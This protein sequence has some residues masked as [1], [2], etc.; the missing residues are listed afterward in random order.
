M[1]NISKSIL[2]L[3][4]IFSL[5]AEANT[6]QIELP[7]TLTDGKN[8]IWDI[9]RNGSIEDGSDDAFDNAAVV[10]NFPEFSTAQ[11]EN[12]C[13][14]II[15]PAQTSNLSITRKIFVSD[16]YGYAR[17]LESVHNPGETNQS[18]S[19]IITFVLGS[20]SSTHIVQ[21]S[22]NDLNLTR[23]DSWLIT[24]DDNSDSGDPTLLFIF[25]NDHGEKPTSIVQ[26]GDTLIC[27]FD[28]ELA[29]NQTRSIMYFVSQNQNQNQALENANR[30]SSLPSDTLQLLE[31]SERNTIQ[32]F[33]MPMHLIIPDSANESD[34]ILFNQATVSIPYPL[35]ETTIINIHSADT[36]EVTVPLTITMASGL[37]STS[38]D[39]NI[40]DDTILD[41]TQTVKISVSNDFLGETYA[42][43]EI[44]DNETATLTLELP[45]NANEGDGILSGRG[46]VFLS[47]AV[48]SPVKIYLSSKNP[49]KM[50]VPEYVLMPS[51]QDSVTFDL[52]IIDDNLIDESSVV[53][54]TAFVEGWNSGS[55][56]ITI[57]DN[58]DKNITITCPESFNENDGMVSG[59][60]MISLS[61]IIQNTLTVNLFSNN[62]S[63]LTVPSMVTIPSGEQSVSFPVFVINN[64]TIDTNK[65]VQISAS[66]TGWND[67]I[68]STTIIDDESRILL[69]TI[70]E[71]A[72]EG[73]GI[74]VNAGKIQI[75]GITTQDL[76]ANIQVTP[77]S[78]ISAPLSLTI[79][80]GNSDADF[81]IQIIDDDLLDGSQKI[82]IHVT[83]T[84]FES[85]S[86]TIFVHDN[87]TATLTLSMP[88]QVFE[89]QG[90]LS[91]Q[92]SVIVNKTV[93]K[94]IPIYL[95]SSDTT[96]IQVPESI[97]IPSGSLSSLFTLTVIDDLE[98]DGSQTATITASV[99][100][101]ISAAYNIE[102]QDNN[103]LELII[104]GEARETDEIKQGSVSISGFL[105]SDLVVHLSSSDSSEVEVPLTLTISAGTRSVSF[106]LSIV[107]DQMIDG[108]QVA[109][110][111]ASHENWIQD[112]KYIKILEKGEDSG[113]YGDDNATNNIPIG[114]DFDYWGNSYSSFGVST[115]G[116]ISLLNTAS[117]TYGNTNFPDPK[118][119]DGIIAPFFDD[120]RMDSTGQPTG[121]VFYLTIGKEP[122]RIL[123][124]QYHDVYFFGS[125][126]PMG[127]FETILYEGTNQIKFQYRFLRDE[128]S[129]GNSAT[130]GLDCP[131]T[132]TYLR[133]SYN[134]S[135]LTEQK[136]ILFDPDGQGGYNINENAYYSWIDISGLT[137]GAPNDGGYY[138]SDK[139]LFT[140][141]PTIN[142]NAYRLDISTS[143]SD[144]EIIESIELSDVTS[145]LYT[146]NLI[147]DETYY[148]RIAASMNNGG[149]YQNPSLFSDGIL[150]DKT[151]PD[152]NQPHASAGP[153]NKS[154]IFHFSGTDNNVITS[155][156]IQIS[157]KPDDFSDPLIDTSIVT[158]IFSYNGEPQQTLFARAFAI[159]AAGNKSQASTISNEFVVPWPPPVIT[160]ITPDHGKSTGHEIVTIR[161]LYFQADQADSIITFGGTP[162]LSYSRWTST[163]II[164]EAPP[165]T[166]GSHTVVCITSSGTGRLDNAFTMTDPV[167]HLNSSKYDYGR[168]FI[169]EEF[170]Y[171]LSI[172]NTGNDFLTVSQAALTG[173][174][175]PNFSLSSDLCSAHSLTPTQRCTL[176]I[177]FTPK[178]SG[179]I[180][181]Q[182]LIYSNDPQHSP[183]SFILE[184][185]GI[186]ADLALDECRHPSLGTAGEDIEV[187][188]S[189]TNNGPYE[190]D[191]INHL[192]VDK[193]FLSFDEQV[194]EDD[195]EIGSFEYNS[196]LLSSENYSLTKN[197]QLPTT[198][199]GDYWI[200]IATDALDQVEEKNDI[201]NF[202][203]CSSINIKGP[204]LIIEIIDTP[205]E[206][207]KGQS[208][209][210]KWKV[211]NIGFGDTAHSWKDCIYL[212]NDD[213][214][215]GDRLVACKDYPVHLKPGD[216]YEE[217]IEVLIPEVTDGQHY[218]VLA[219]DDGDNQKE[220]NEAD[221]TDISP[222]LMIYSPPDFIVSDISAPGSALA[223][224][225]VKITWKITNI[226]VK[227]VDGHWQDTVYLSS[228]NQI[229]DDIFA[230]SFAYTGTVS[231]GRSYSVAHDIYIPEDAVGNYYIVVEA[232]SQN[233][234]VEPVG[235]DDNMSIDDVTIQIL[236]SDLKPESCKIPEIAGPGE[237]IQIEWTVANIGQLTA[238]NSWVDNIYLSEDSL[239]GNDVA[240]ISFPITIPFLAPGQNCHIEKEFQ[241]PHISGDYYLIFV[242]DQN[243]Q[244][245]ETNKN[246]NTTVCGPITIARPNLK[247]QHISA[248]S[249][250]FQGESMN[251]HW[252][253]S[254]DGN[255]SASSSWNDCVYLSDDDQQ[256]NDMLLFCVD[257]SITLLS[258]ESYEVTETYNVP[259]VEEGDH[260][261]IVQAN[262]NGNQLETSYVDNVSA[263]KI[264]V[265]N[266][267][268]A[269]PDL[270]FPSEVMAYESF[271]MTWTVNNNGGSIAK[272]A[273]TDKIFLSRDQEIGNDILLYT[274]Q[275]STPLAPHTGYTQTVQSTTPGNLA[276]DYYIIACTDS[277][278]MINEFGNEFNNYW[279]SDHIVT[280]YQADI[281]ITDCYVPDHA[282]SGSSIQISYTIANNGNVRTNG[283][284]I[285]ALYFSD[286]D[287]IGNDI[288]ITQI[289]HENYLE[290]NQLYQVS[291]TITIPSS[292]TIGTWHVIIELDTV[293][294]VVE[295]NENNNSQICGTIQLAGPDLIISMLPHQQEPVY[296]KDSMNISWKV[297]N[298]GNAPALAD[299]KDCFYLSINPLQLDDH[300][301]YCFERLMTLN[302]DESYT[303]TNSI[304]VPNYD[305]GNYLLI[306][307]TD[308]EKSQAETDEQNNH[309]SAKEIILLQPHLESIAF[310]DTD[311]SQTV[312]SGDEYYF[313]F[314]RQM[315]PLLLPDQTNNANIK[316]TPENNRIYGA[317]NQLNWKDQNK[318]V[319][320]KITNGFSITGN[321]MVSP[322][323]IKDLQGNLAIQSQRLTITDTIIPVIKEIQSNYPSSTV[324]ATENYQ[325]TIVFSESMNT[326]IHPVIEFTSSA[327]IQPSL[328]SAKGKWHSLS[329]INNIMYALP[330]VSLTSGMDGRIQ[331][332]ISA[333]RDASGNEMLAVENAFEFILDATPPQAPQI[334]LYSMTNNSITVKWDDY[335]APDDL[336]QYE[337]YIAT[338]QFQ[339]IENMIPVSKLE[340]N[341]DSYTFSELEPF[342]T[343]YITIVAVDNSGNK[344]EA[345]S[346]MPVS[347]NSLISFDR[348][349][350]AATTGMAEISL[351]DTTLNSDSTSPQTIYINVIS[352]SDTNGINLGLKETG[353][354][355]GVFTTSAYGQNVTFSEDMSDN[356]NKII[357]VAEGDQVTAVYNDIFYSITKLAKAIIDTKP[358]VTELIINDE[359]YFDGT[360]YYMPVNFTYIMSATDLS[361]GIKH[362]IYRIDDQAFLNYTAPF[363]LVQSGEYVLYYQ[364]IDNAGNQ[365]EL[366]HISII[367]DTPPASP[368]N[369]EGTQQ[370]YQLTIRWQAPQ[371]SD[372]AGYNLYRNGNRVNTQFL[373]N[374]QYTE[375]VVSGQTNTYNVTAIDWRGNESTFSEAYIM[376]AEST[377]PVITYPLSGTVTFNSKIK[378]NGDAEPGSIVEIFVNG[379]NQGKSVVSKTG[380][381]GKTGILVAEGENTLTAVSTSSHGIE[382]ASSEALR[383]TLDEKP[384]A[385]SGL[386]AIANDTVVTLS[387]EKNQETD[388][389]GYN[390]YRDN[391]RINKHLISTT[392]YTDIGLTN[393]RP[394][395]YRIKAI[396]QRD[397]EG[398][399]SAKITASPVPGEEWEISQ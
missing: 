290:G 169:D 264:Y 310:N 314:T 313:F 88:D 278:N 283:A 270:T 93:D 363:M 216:F 137:S 20:D 33:Q 306:A 54:V 287:Q 327:Q 44:D 158:G 6:E 218:F 385:P 31:D 232:D 252:K 302:P 36:S 108:T 301:I 109:M 8:F 387:W 226:G 133:Y 66:S 309:S 253:I 161:G 180:Q 221:N 101:W 73:D 323:A 319:I 316:L 84:G 352:N 192:W 130:I 140:W 15:G 325:L 196:P 236:Q 127:T 243:N 32:N 265:V 153:E 393:D 94:N 148:A 168:V 139:I 125:N 376:L 202:K 357:Q 388:I 120:L 320:V 238:T 96:E 267:D 115:N 364:S 317:I 200:I 82:D 239:T 249:T 175:A 326:E 390:I 227:N 142:A 341:N 193:I 1:I 172:S 122:E 135:S 223:G 336:Y 156:H 187:Y 201:D 372:L 356:L 375:F 337:S 145:C 383:I 391:E 128:R 207:I 79:Y 53:T 208:C 268:L 397:N 118:G 262:D 59:S 219:V 284:W 91:D 291:Q 285:D 197:I 78:E 251:I 77:L 159:D 258:D 338:S 170:S 51:N 37:T 35:T 25:S 225:H 69:L 366:K 334:S 146:N 136:A 260:W 4:T 167:L 247:L 250:V 308:N 210:I 72:G 230:G 346:S 350:Y 277:E 234:V 111:S 195:I 206:A 271:E 100:G 9:Q 231:S 40:I 184:G 7:V 99:P 282:Q 95:N 46:T 43:I 198:A 67:A 14:V 280:V 10:T 332:N 85:D 241:L 321:E 110:I 28:L 355:T 377:P 21:T 98:F 70:P 246:N 214:V 41:G 288:E 359:V 117:G 199:I 29:P 307:A 394:Y 368:S 194:G 58:E 121:K 107:N 237:T 116:W 331:V 23:D 353:P 13:Q 102:V 186:K 42:N 173:T 381:F 224:Q 345:V 235:D 335:Q 19:L 176:T 382:S 392:T 45:D 248:S 374:T 30:L 396:D 315:N 324:T 279:I 203:I 179:R 330:P 261:I 395:T 371:D 177:D 185:T 340:I 257:H 74:L 275:N 329:G 360:R 342:N 24:D 389:K 80:A 367:I 81:D 204:D 68:I 343:F 154:V 71:Q 188:W 295:M 333:A 182:L 255:V 131:Y 189:V 60:A 160:E 328:P 380:Y 92:C 297:E 150:I 213:Q 272:D 62:H 103:K 298:I 233:D 281:Q 63:A 49:A 348:Q 318:I 119:K 65:N 378:V 11:L 112:T 274:F 124:I 39:L 83:I 240:E 386:T 143:T 344:L 311:G 55:D 373:E 134:T 97:V 190:V 162:A 18:F 370:D 245:I 259:Y 165:G 293:H 384:V 141:Q 299:W 163:E 322:S 242:V 399:A 104:P 361:S 303:N 276:G 215:G 17:F 398:S 90:E 50:T 211:K 144:A 300:L 229:G 171:D 263:Q 87:E 273:W 294:T 76:S 147:E 304:T 34:N 86:E 38:F 256:G 22:N 5:F 166:I 269:I 347:I 183:V 123:V 212:S 48:E 61:G 205:T 358:P 181:A 220:N 132:N 296:G 3:L 157:D 152:I 106:D 379:I 339:S 75:G 369:I 149:T 349:Y 254:N 217:L 52:T 27:Q 244:I 12:D 312:T 138:A 222:P 26:N 105:E 47:S 362:T 129:Y 365:E 114:F 89:W 57:N 228:D 286:D 164:C 56:F 155:Y 292:L 354:D 351:T 178:K 126:L 2:L 305:E 191:N 209:T 113:L 151:P 289:P 64:N 174:D 266:P 16:N